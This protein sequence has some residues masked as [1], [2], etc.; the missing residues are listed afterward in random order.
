MT[1]HDRSTALYRWLQARLLPDQLL[2]RRFIATHLPSADEDESFTRA[3]LG[4]FEEII[5]N[6]IALWAKV[7][8]DAG[9]T[10]D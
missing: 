7:V 1:G 5:K 9:I 4:Q 2:V 10:A 8:E 3:Q 6:D